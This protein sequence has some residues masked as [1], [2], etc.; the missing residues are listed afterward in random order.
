[1]LKTNPKQSPNSLQFYEEK[2]RWGCYRRKVWSQQRLVR[3]KEKNSLHNIK[4]QSEGADAEDAANYPEN[5]AKVINEGGYTKQPIVSVGKTAFC[6]KRMPF[7]TFITWDE[8]SMPGFKASKDWLILLLEVGL[9]GGSVVKNPPANAGGAGDAGLIPRS[10]RFP[11]G[12]D[13][14]LENL[15]DKGSWLAI[16]QVVKKSWTWLI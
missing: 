1:M 16:V 3:F 13:C 10:G 6:W 2:E 14:C 12:G 5:L 11:G 7:K 9:L 4:V 15:M 8:K